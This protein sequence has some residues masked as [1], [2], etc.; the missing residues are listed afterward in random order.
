[1]STIKN[2]AIIKTDIEHV[3]TYVLRLKM[4]FI[5]ASRKENMVLIIMLIKHKIERN[6]IYETL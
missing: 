3:K 5:A 6:K 2:H 1:M 4:I